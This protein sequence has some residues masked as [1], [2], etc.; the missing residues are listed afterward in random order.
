M[1]RYLVDAAPGAEGMRGRSNMSSL[2][3][4]TISERTMITKREKAVKGLAELSVL[5]CL[6]PDHV[7]DSMD[8][9]VY[10]LINPNYFDFEEDILDPILKRK[11]RSGSKTDKAAISAVELTKKILGESKMTGSKM[12]ATGES[13]AAGATSGSKLGGGAGSG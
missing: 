13:Q 1:A 7:I 11:G 2:R 5:R 8:R 12:S 4:K 6:R 3:R 9:F 10:N